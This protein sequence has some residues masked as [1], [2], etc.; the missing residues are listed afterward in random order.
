MH[1]RLHSA[2]HLIVKAV[3]HHPAKIFTLYA[4]VIIRTFTT[5]CGG[6]RNAKMPALV[7]PSFLNNYLNVFF[8]SH[9][10]FYM[11]LIAV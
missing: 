5:V 6:R 11:T 7:P 1:P 8:K 2:G 3:S 4:G 10:T 9:F